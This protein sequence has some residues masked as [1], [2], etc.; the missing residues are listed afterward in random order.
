MD[1]EDNNNNVVGVVEDEM[2]KIQ[3]FF[4]NFQEP[5]NLCEVKERVEQFITRQETAPIVLITV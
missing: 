1:L 5:A 3:N 2:I 4:S